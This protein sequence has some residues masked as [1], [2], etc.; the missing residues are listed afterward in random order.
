MVRYLRG[1][2]K[3]RTA[4]PTITRRG[5]FELAHAISTLFQIGHTE[6]H[7]K[8]YTHSVKEVRQAL[9][10]NAGETLRIQ[11]SIDGLT[12]AVCIFRKDADCKFTEGGAH[13]TSMQ[14]CVWSRSCVP[15]LA[16]PS[17]CHRRCEVVG[18]PPLFGCHHCRVV[19]AASMA[20]TPRAHVG[21]F[22]VAHAK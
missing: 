6:E 10:V 7:H 20:G 2:K 4:S 5:T 16:H 22:G 15:A 21:P 19:R 12:N 13:D 14:P 1:A 18:V 8:L 11:S 9:G 17:M 3:S